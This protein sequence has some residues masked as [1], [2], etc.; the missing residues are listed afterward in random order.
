MRNTQLDSLEYAPLFFPYNIINSELS[1]DPR[2]VEGSINTFVTAGGKLTKRPGTISTGVMGSLPANRLPVRL[3]AVETLDGYLWYLCSMQHTDL[4]ISGGYEMY[5]KQAGTLSLWA[6]LGTL[7]GMDESTAPHECVVQR[8]IA[9]I[10][11]TPDPLSGELYSTVSFD[12]TGGTAKVRLWGVPAPTV[13]CRMSGRTTFLSADIDASTT[14]LTVTADFS[15]AVATSFTIQIDDERM[16]VTAKGGGG[17]V[18]WTVT[19]GYDGTTATEHYAQAFVIY[20]DWAA[21]AHR[22][23][24]VT[25]WKYTYAWHSITGQVSNRAPLETNPDLMSSFTFPFFDQCPKMNVQGHADTTNIDKVYIY[26][27]QDGGG[28]FY[29]VGQVTN[30]GAGDIS[31]EDKHLETGPTYAVEQDPIPDDLLDSGNIA[32][33]LTSNTVPPTVTPPAVIG[34]DFPKAGS[35][36]E[37]YQ[38][39]LWFAIKNYLY[40][41]GLEE[42]T[43][44]VP[45]ECFPAGLTG[46]FFKFQ[47]PITGLRAG[48]SALY[49]F[50]TQHTYKVE[51]VDKQ[52]FTVKP[53]LHNIGGYSV[54]ST[55][56]AGNMIYFMTHDRRVGAIN[57]N[58]SF[59]FVSDPLGTSTFNFSGSPYPTFHFEYWGEGSKDLLVI[60]MNNEQSTTTSKVLVLDNTLSQKTQSPFWHAPWTVLGTCCLTAKSSAGAYEKRLLFGTPTTF[61]YFDFSAESTWLD[62]TTPYDWVVRTHL[63]TVP[64]GNHVNTLRKLG[65]VPATVRVKFERTRI[66]GDVVPQVTLAY[67][68]FWT[69]EVPAA[70]VH[71]PTGREPSK[72]YQTVLADTDRVSY[73]LGIGLAVYSS[74]TAITI[75]NIG[76]TWNP[77]AGLME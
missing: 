65:L 31:F 76:M 73:R 4:F 75:H 45:E 71:E 9:Y 23:D 8:G 12:G 69:R 62:V 27:S 58:D 15:P 32:P 19:R 35:N 37:S 72:W 43:E 3:Y 6:S 26:R 59:D 34:T 11:G 64:A 60:F 16:L 41:S 20:H 5:Y 29:Y 47:Y 74:A 38:G 61:L 7:R 52:S 44:G 28:D 42:I 24:V 50:T 49:V 13:P 70:A 48:K 21:S 54:T 77:D 36:I 66:A 53:L 46:N 57:A 30:T 67:D 40:F 18:N 17:L 39:R 22:V 63:M 10:R 2:L 51:G 25:G 14:S 55:V 33:S 68:D 56:R 1:E